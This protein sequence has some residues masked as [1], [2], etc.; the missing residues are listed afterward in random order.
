MLRPCYKCGGTGNYGAVVCSLCEGE[1]SA[2][3]PAEKQLRRRVSALEEQVRAI[4]SAK[5]G[6][7]NAAHYIAAALFLLA[8]GAIGCGL[9][10]YVAL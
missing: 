1:G 4:R 9:A 7:P 5:K 2:P 8:G 10:V 6:R 3:T